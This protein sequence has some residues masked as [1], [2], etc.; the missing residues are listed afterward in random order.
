MNKAYEV[1]WIEKVCGTLQTEESQAWYQNSNGDTFAQTGILPLSHENPS[2]YYILNCTVLLYK[3]HFTK[4]TINSIS[5][6]ARN[7]PEVFTV[8]V[9]VNY[10]TVAKKPIK[11]NYCKNLKM[12]SAFV[13]SF[14]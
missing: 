2:E 4:I 14:R 12:S 13:K 5:L 3:C 10:E 11:N 9:M 7:W 8:S 6:P 1:T